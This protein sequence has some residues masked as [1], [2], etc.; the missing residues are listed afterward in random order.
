MKKIKP[1]GNNAYS[2][3]RVNVCQQV[4][5]SVASFG[6]GGHESASKP[7]Q[8]ICKPLAFICSKAQD[9][10]V[11][12]RAF[13]KIVFRLANEIVPQVG[14]TKTTKSSEKFLVFKERFD[15]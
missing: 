15:G 12:N 1:A 9:I 4:F 14:Q 3:W 13:M 5:R 8:A 2:L 11:N 10:F 6:L 7:P